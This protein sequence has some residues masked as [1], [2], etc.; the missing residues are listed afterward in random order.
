[1]FENRTQSNNPAKPNVT[2]SISLT[3]TQ[4]E[5]LLA[6]SKEIANQTRKHLSSDYTTTAQIASDN[7]TPV[8]VIIVQP[9]IGKPLQKNLGTPQNPQES[10]YM[11]PEQRDEIANTL[12]AQAVLQYKQFAKDNVVQTGG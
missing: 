12:A 2:N 4:K 8:A 1:M 3:T 7:D 9:P 6:E 10:T 11:P 5:R